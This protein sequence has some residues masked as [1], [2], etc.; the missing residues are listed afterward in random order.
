[1]NVWGQ[2]PLA[3]QLFVLTIVG[4]FVGG[5]VNRGIYRL[6]WTPR[7]IGPWSAPPPDAPGRPWWARLPIV[8]WW[9][10]RAESAMHGAGFWRRPIVIEVALAIAYPLLYWWECSGGLLPEAARRVAEAD[11]SLAAFGLH[12][13]LL[14]L[15]V[16]ATFID[17]DEQTIPD[18]ITLPGT[19]L[20]LLL[21]AVI[22]AGA[23]PIVMRPAANGIQQVVPLDLLSPL[24]WES[25]WDGATGVV[26][27]VGCWAAWCLAIVPR[28]WTTRRG[29]RKAFV[30]LVSSIVRSGW[31]PRIATV[32]ALG[33]ASIGF[34][35]WVGGMHWRGLLSGLYGM[36]FSGGMVW[37]IRVAAGIAL[38]EE[39]MGFGDVTL[40]GMIG[41]FL[42][43]Q[44]GLLAFFLAPAGA[45][46]VSVGQWLLTRRRDIAFGPYLCVGAAGVVGAWPRLWGSWGAQFFALSWLI[47]L[48]LAPCL[49]LMAGMLYAWALLKQRI[50][51][52]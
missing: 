27:G 13:T 44:A 26:V 47:P 43:W 8:G 42:G 17:F 24:D 29:W 49:L 51:A 4:A 10:L 20:G 16:V 5:Q 37:L 33:A 39:A 1:M 32:F 14:P 46:V 41:A 11:A 36:A 48:C 52:D 22:P 21:S 2:L 18:A 35:W 3:I 9:G 23:L 12:A 19:A 28:T 50:F 31:L 7:S 38:G 30:Y 6:A 25:R 45:L 40:M 15:L 34:T